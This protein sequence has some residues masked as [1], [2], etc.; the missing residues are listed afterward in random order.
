MKKELWKLFDENYKNK[1]LLIFL[2]VTFIFFFLL[3]TEETFDSFIKF[4]VLF[5]FISFFIRLINMIKTSF[6]IKKV[7]KEDWIKI[8]EDLKTPLIISDH[9]Y[10][11][12]ENYIIK[13]IGIPAIIKIKDI[14]LIHKD[15]IVINKYYFERLTIYTKD[16]KK[17][18]F[19]FK[20]SF[21]Y[22]TF[23]RRNDLVTILLRLNKDILIGNNK[24]NK[25]EIYNKYKINL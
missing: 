24:N 21:F 15:N 9:Y 5:I 11:V 6:I 3:V 1:S 20:Q 17:Y 2:F 12:T 13:Q 10:I 14:I 18:I 19:S 8:K 23:D 7:N 4:I 16:G 25:K 22:K